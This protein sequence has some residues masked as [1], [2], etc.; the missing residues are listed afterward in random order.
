MEYTVT[1]LEGLVSFISPCILPMLPIYISYFAGKSQSRVR[2]FARAVAFVLGFSCIFCLLGF[3]A[4]SLGGLLHS[5]HTAVDIACGII[6]VFLGLHFLGAIKLPFFKGFGASPKVSGVF[7][8]FAFGA[9]F[10]LAHLPCIGAFLGSALMSASASGS[11]QKGFFML[12]SYSFGMGVPFL[13]SAL[14]IQKLSL[15]F[16]KIRNNYKI[17]NPICGSLLIALGLLMAS[18]LLHSFM[19]I[20]LPH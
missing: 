18:G 20:T 11:A 19:H 16:D 6:I 13:V 17:I 8:A 7:S 2:I 15:F 14:L 1:F 10:S 12:L 3:F 9:V 4:G 5:Y